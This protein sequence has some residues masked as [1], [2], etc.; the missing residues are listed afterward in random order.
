MDNGDFYHVT[1]ERNLE[2]IE[3]MGLTPK[4][5]KT[6]FVHPGD[7]IY[8]LQTKRV[9]LFEGLKKQIADSQL[10]ALLVRQPNLSYKYWNSMTPQNMVVLKVDLDDSYDLYS[11]PM[12]ISM[13]NSYLAV[14]VKKNIPPSKIIL[15]NY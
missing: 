8:L 10:K 3:Q 5:S 11:D 4:L 13:K 1:F 2:K 7:R 15:T 14:F 9:D 12:F 6:V